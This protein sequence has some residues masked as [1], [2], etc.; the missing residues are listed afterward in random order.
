MEPKLAELMMEAIEEYGGEADL[1]DDYSGGEMYGQKTHAIVTDLDEN[2]LL[3]A[4]VCNASLFTDEDGSL[5]T[6]PMFKTD[7]YS[8]KYSTMIIY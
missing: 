5:F 8:S 7:E 6:D 2:E 1:V 3:S 4:I